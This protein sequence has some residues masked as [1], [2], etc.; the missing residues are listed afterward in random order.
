M[1][2]GNDHGNCDYDGVS[3]GGGDEIVAACC[4]GNAFPNFGVAVWEQRDKRSSQECNGAIGQLCI[5][6]KNLELGKK[7]L[8]RFERDLIYMT[9]SYAL[10]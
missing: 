8:Y 3:D 4:C 9:S 2:D 1:N 6:Q 7:D 10:Q 5:V